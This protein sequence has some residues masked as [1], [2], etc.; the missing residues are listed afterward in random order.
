ML[1]RWVFFQKISILNYDRQGVEKQQ[2]I[3]EYVVQKQA[4][5][6]PARRMQ[7]RSVLYREKCGNVF[8]VE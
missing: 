2:K 3:W 4:P 8:V 1:V 6:H 7:A 5:I